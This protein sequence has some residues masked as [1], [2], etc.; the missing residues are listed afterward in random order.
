MEQN[1]NINN[2]IN[3]LNSIKNEELLNENFLKNGKFN[4]VNITKI[5]NAKEI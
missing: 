4:T 5:E 1:A 3:E 2:A